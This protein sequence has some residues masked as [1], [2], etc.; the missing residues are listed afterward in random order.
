M[1]TH[2]ARQ[3]PAHWPQSG[4]IKFEG[5]TM[6]YRDNLPLVLNSMDLTVAA[7]EKVGIVGRTGAGARRLLDTHPNRTPPRAAQLNP[8]HAPLIRPGGAAR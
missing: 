1:M 8:T 3:P 4:A 7:Q 2:R 6:R 5:V